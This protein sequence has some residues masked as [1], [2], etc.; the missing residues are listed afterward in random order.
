MSID[1]AA[2]SFWLTW[3][4][5][6]IAF[7]AGGGLAYTLVRSVD[8]VADGAIAGAVT[9]AVIGIAQWLALHRIHPLIK[10]S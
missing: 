8:G 4:L 6:F 7:P 1:R 3:L 2:A 10:T 9:G 5:T